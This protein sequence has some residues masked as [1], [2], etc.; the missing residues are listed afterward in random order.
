LKGDGQEPLEDT[1]PNYDSF[2]NFI[3]N[4]AELGFV[5]YKIKVVEESPYNV[6]LRIKQIGVPYFNFLRAALP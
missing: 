6:T 4:L 5:N 1:W 3:L 2:N